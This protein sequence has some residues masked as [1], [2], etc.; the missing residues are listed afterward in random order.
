MIPDPDHPAG[1][2]P[3]L[4]KKHF[5]YGISWLIKVRW[6]IGAG[7]AAVLLLAQYGLKM[8]SYY[9]GLWQVWAVIL[10][11]NSAF[12]LWERRLKNRPV[13]EAEPQAEILTGLQIIFDIF[14]LAFILH[15]TGGAENPISIF[16]I[17]PVIIAS[18]LFSKRNAYLL[19][20]LA[21]TLIGGIFLL[22][23][24]GLLKHYHL[25]L[26]PAA[27]CQPGAYVFLIWTV[28]ALTLLSSAYMASSIVG[29]LHQREEE[30]EQ[31]RQSLLEQTQKCEM[32]Y[33]QLA[34]ASKERLEF[35]RKVA[36]ELRSPLAAI[37]SCL[38]VARQYY[39]AK[40]AGKP[41]ELLERAERRAEGLTAL[42][43]DL[44]NLSRTTEA[45]ITHNFQP[46][47]LDNI[48]QGVVNLYLPKAREKR[49]EI[50]THIQPQVKLTADAQGME[51]VFTNLL[52]NAIKYSPPQTQVTVNLKAAPDCILIEFA[53]QGIGI[54]EEDLNL[55]FTEFFRAKNAKAL[56]VEGTGLGLTIS[57]RI[58]EAHGGT[59]NVSSQLGKGARFCISLP[60]R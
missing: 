7:I 42:V 9:P 55:L 51:A 47:M 15:Y 33:A 3:A 24:V 1:D 10:A 44:L 39:G 12:W 30:L 49:I 13:E 29:K 36:H 54:A 8:G 53:D 14:V 19:S 43:R 26:L 37:V 52:S 32:S 21:I 34:Q 50:V 23:S 60:L 31:A 28:L 46:V 41:G 4:S 48:L 20:L 6:A 25:T 59:I 57:R 56:P 58:V 2:Y 40:L 11:Y 5:L 27:F 16:F 17:F 35:M 22:E 38:A 45:T 18:I